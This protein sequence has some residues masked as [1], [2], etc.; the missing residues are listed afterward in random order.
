MKIENYRV[1]MVSGY[2]REYVKRAQERI[3]IIRA[4]SSQPVKVQQ[5]ETRDQLSEKDKAKLK[6]IKTI[7]EKLT[8]RKVKLLLL[9]INESHESVE[10]SDNAN[11]QV[12]VTYERSGCERESETVSFSTRGYVERK[13]GRRIEFEINFHLS[14]NFEQN[15]FMRFIAGNLQDPLVLRLDDAPLEFSDRKL[16]LNINF[17][18]VLDEM[19]LPRN[20]GLLMLDLNEN[21]KLDDVH[22]LFGPLYKDFWSL[23]DTMRTETTRSIKMMLFLRS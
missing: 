8:G 7:L 17:D 4:L 1:V 21:G 6:L 13:D 15:E 11:V 5:S 14:R 22:E 23:P 12:G 20:T 16:T 2:S 9:E 10:R 18:G 19:R 3:Q